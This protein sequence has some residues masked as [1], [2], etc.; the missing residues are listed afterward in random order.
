MDSLPLDCIYSFMLNLPYRDLLAYGCVC[1][2]SHALLQQPFLWSQKALLDY[3]VNISQ[4]SRLQYLRVLSENGCEQGSEKFLPPRKC[5]RRAG[6]QGNRRLIRYFGSLFNRVDALSHLV[7]GATRAGNLPLVKELIATHPN[8][9][10]DI[11]TFVEKDIGRSGRQDIVEYFGIPSIKNPYISPP[12]NTLRI[13]DHQYI[14]RFC[15]GVGQSGNHKLL[16]YLDIIMEPC[17]NLFS[18]AMGAIKGGHYEIFR[19][20]I[21]RHRGGSYSY[22][23]KIVIKYRRDDFIPYL[24]DKIEIHDS[25]LN[26]L[27]YEASKY[28]RSDII[29]ILLAKN[30]YSHNSIQMGLWGA[31]AGGHIGLVDFFI[32]KGA[33][34]LIGALNECIKKYRKRKDLV[35]V[36]YLIAKILSNNPVYD[37]PNTIDFVV[38]MGDADLYERFQRNNTDL[39]RDE[40]FHPYSGVVGSIRHENMPLLRKILDTHTLTFSDYKNI[41]ISCIQG[42]YIDALQIFVPLYLSK[43]DEVGIVEHSTLLT[44]LA[45]HALQDGSLLSL[46]YLIVKGANPNFLCVIYG[47]LVEVNEYLEIRKLTNKN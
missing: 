31:S 30:L 25:Y 41:C 43:S 14:R 4:G 34:D 5:L 13:P 35:M 26:Q 9:L 42:S 12:T 15:E 33:T 46:D 23:L 2:R 16:S 18:I 3:S 7:G 32:E 11:R 21:E 24:L 20:Y 28:N 39:I 1:Q 19:R 40:R 45:R 6:K 44:D 8:G 22:C 36:D 37:F 27:M 10:I 29:N 47:N 38:E 17:L